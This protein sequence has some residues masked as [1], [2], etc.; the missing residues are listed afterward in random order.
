MCSKRR[1]KEGGRG[2]ASVLL[3][4]AWRLVCNMSPGVATHG[5]GRLV[6]VTCICCGSRGGGRVAG[7]PGP[8][9]SVMFTIVFRISGVFGVCSEPELSPC[10]NQ[11]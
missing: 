4:S 5:D 9:V 2:T 6:W 1:L 11:R 10:T 8:S 3:V 7:W